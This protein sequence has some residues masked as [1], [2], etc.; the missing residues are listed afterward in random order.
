M[1]FQDGLGLGILAARMLRVGLPDR[2]TWPLPGAAPLPTSPLGAHP[3]RQPDAQINPGEHCGEMSQ[4]DI[5]SPLEQ[6][7]HFKTAL[8]KCPSTDEQIHK[9]RYTRTMEYYSA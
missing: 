2:H 5:Q 8:P 9:L 7:L 6:A 1:E 4:L 3:P